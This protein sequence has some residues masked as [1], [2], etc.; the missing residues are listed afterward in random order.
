MESFS[1]GNS[2]IS[3]TGPTAKAL[4]DIPFEQWDDVVENVAAV[5]PRTGNKRIFFC[6]S[7]MAEVDPKRRELMAK[8]VL[9]L[10]SLQDGYEVAHVILLLNYLDIQ[11]CD[12]VVEA[13]LLLAPDRSPVNMIRILGSYL[14]NIDV[15]MQ[16]A[17]QIQEKCPKIKSIE[18]VYETIAKTEDPKT[19]VD[20][21]MPLLDEETIERY[22]SVEVIGNLARIKPDNREGVVAAAQTLLQYAPNKVGLHGIVFELGCV[23]PKELAHVIENVLSSISNPSTCMDIHHALKNRVGKRVG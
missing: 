1:L 14:E 20:L 2:I 8:Q 5:A 6:I 11:D 23:D 13:A 4:S 12:R 21:V 9:R 7:A 16:C 10:E 18:W 22:G 17:R 19:F 15:L 3:D